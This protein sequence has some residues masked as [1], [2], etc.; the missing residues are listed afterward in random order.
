M[1]IV[2]TERLL[3]LLLIIIIIIIN[4]QPS[5]INHQPSTIDHRPSTIKEMVERSPFFQELRVSSSDEVLQPLRGV[6]WLRLMQAFIQNPLA[7]V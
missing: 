3:L 4:H 5:T 7:V 2:T 1:M 6:P